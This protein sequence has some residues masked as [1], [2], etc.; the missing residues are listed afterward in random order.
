MQKVLR[1]TLTSHTLTKVI[2]NGRHEDLHNAI[3]MLRATIHVDLA[4]ELVYLRHDTTL[5]KYVNELQVGRI[6]SKNKYHV[7]EVAIKELEILHSV[8]KAALLDLCC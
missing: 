3:I 7:A 8:L 2:S 4:S 1:E 5:Q 6:K